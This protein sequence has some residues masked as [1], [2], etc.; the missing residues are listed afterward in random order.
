MVKASNIIIGFTWIDT[1]GP[2]ELGS[3]SSGWK[4]KMDFKACGWLGAGRYEMEGHVLSPEGL[5]VRR[6]RG[7]WNAHFEVAPCSPKGEATGPYMKIWQARRKPEGDAY[8]FTNFARSLNHAKG[9]TPRASDSRRRPDRYFLEQGESGL[10][11]SAKTFVEETQR[12]ERKVREEKGEKWEPRWFVP[13]AFD[14][15]QVGEPEPAH[16]PIWKWKGEDMTPLPVG[17]E[18]GDVDGKGFLPWQYPEELK[19]AL[20]EEAQQ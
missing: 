14:D 8:G 20:W 5:P 2:F 11:Q 15:A 19:P 17:E 1:Y 3:T 12:K 7:K 4:V 18:G 10:A 13:A 9:F 16:F 6:V